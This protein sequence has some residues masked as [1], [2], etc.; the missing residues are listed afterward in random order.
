MLQAPFG[1]LWDT[2]VFGQESLAATAA[3]AAKSVAIAATAAEKQ[4]D[5]DDA[6]TVAATES[7]KS[8]AATASAYKCLRR[9]MYN[10]ILCQG[11][12]AVYT[13]YQKNF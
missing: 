12:W 8:V 9:F 4:Q 6:A 3:A 1:I 13:N 2:L 11:A 7:A 5:P 10:V